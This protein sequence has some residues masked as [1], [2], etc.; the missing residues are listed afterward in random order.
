MNESPKAP[1]RQAQ[2]FMELNPIVSL[3]QILRLERSFK[4]VS[5]VNLVVSR[6]DVFGIT[7]SGLRQ[8]RRPKGI[9]VASMGTFQS[10]LE[11]SGV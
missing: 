11:G 8:G 3:Y 4:C 5:L 10:V 1:R 6:S 7:M 9:P 2:P